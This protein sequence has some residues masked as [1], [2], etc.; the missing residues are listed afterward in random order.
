MHTGKVRV[1]I[2]DDSA[3]MR[4][5]LASILSSDPMIEVVGTAQDPYY[6][7]DKIKALQPDVITLDV[8]MPRMDGITFLEKLMHGHPMPV[9]MVSSLTQSGC[10]VTLHALE[11]GAVDFFPKPTIDT[12]TGVAEGA[13]DIVA[14]VK[15]AA[16]VRVHRRD[17]ST[18]TVT[19]APE[20]V[21]SGVAS[22]FRLTNQI[23]AI[24]AST[25]GTEALREVLTAL[26]PAT[27]GIVIVQHMPPGFTAS[28]AER[29]DRVCAIRVKEAED[30]DRVLPGHALIAPGNYQMALRRKGAEYTVRVYMGERV[31]LHRPSVDVL[32]ESCAVHAG[33]NAVGAILTGMGDDGAAGLL[34]MRDAGARTIAQDEATSVVFGMPREAIECGGAEFVLPLGRISGELLKLASGEAPSKQAAHRG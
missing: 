5:L 15:A 26:P 7:R 19:V 25:G 16:K 17:K 13:A 28:F 31:N 18:S 4:Q 30:G 11:L 24:G 20:R 12:L 21:H 22:A 9:V 14:K 2:V 29:M 3:A 1:L 23:I 10:D 27:P 34:Q 32:F 8:E 33:K 6:A